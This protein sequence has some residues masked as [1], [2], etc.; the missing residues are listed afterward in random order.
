MAIKKII[1][2]IV[3]F[4]ISGGICLPLFGERLSI[5]YTGN[6][7]SSL[8][9]CGYCP[10][11]SGGVTRRSKVIKR[12]RKK[13]KSLLLVD[14][15]NFTAGGFLDSSRINASLDK[16][17][18]TYYLRILNKLKYDA[19]AIGEAEFNFGIEF[20]KEIIKKY[21]LPFVS[22]N[23]SLEGVR[24]YIIKDIHSAKVGIV[25]ITDSEVLNKNN[26]SQKDYRISLEKVVKEIKDKVDFI[27]LL[28]SMPDYINEEIANNFKDIRFIISSGGRKAAYSKNKVNNTLIL[29]PSYE[30][31]SLDILDIEMRNNRIEEYSLKKELLPLTVEEDREIKKFFPQCFSDKDCPSKERL[32]VQCD[33]PGTLFARCIYVEAKEI[34]II[35]ITDKQ[36]SFCVTRFTEEYLKKIFAGVNFRIIDYRTKEARQLIKKYGI[37]YLPA[38]I[39]PKTI[40]E[41]NVFSKVSNFLEDKGDKFLIKNDLSGMFLFLNRK[42]IPNNI[43]VFFSIYDHNCFSVLRELKNFCDKKKVALNIYFIYP[44]KEDKSLEASFEKE[45]TKRMLAVK[46][47]YPDKFFSYLMMRLSNI[48]SSWWVEVMDSLGIDYKKIAGF[49]NSNKIKNMLKDNDKLIS[50]LGIDKGI[51]LLI[52][53]KYIFRA[54]KIKEENLSELLRR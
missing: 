42:K 3:I 14:A 34:D 50:Q 37:N 47:L 21:S 10:G 29:K 40:E 13:E 44:P 26:L 20:L 41:E 39:V 23:I 54:Y 35:I 17:R 43:D 22:C 7:Y 33:N 19:I 2:I 45:E 8:Y 1:V 49:I 9:P 6:T 30:A 25:G 52:N 36:C 18:T 38:F 46:Y 12:L 15:G 4:W 16:K 5:V 51:A 32:V 27:I 53:N 48:S 31:K 11:S 24:A 28:S